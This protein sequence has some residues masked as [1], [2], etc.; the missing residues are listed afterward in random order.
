MSPAKTDIQATVEILNLIT[1][2]RQARDRQWWNT[3]RQCYTE[4]AIIEVGWFHGLASEYINQSIEISKGPFGLPATHRVGSPVIHVNG[5]RAVA[6][7]PMIVDFRGKVRKVE[8]D[9]TNYY[10]MLDRLEKS[11]GRWRI[12]ESRA[13]FQS[14]TM[15]PT[16][17]GT[18]FTLTP[19]DFEGLRPS[20]RCML[21]L[22]NPA[23]HPM[24]QECH[25]ID[26]PDAVAELYRRVYGWAGV[27]IG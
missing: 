16:I 23:K 25:G 26:R 9:V 17:P 7:I 15:E 5:D 21:L 1:H 12:A 8:V 24:S 27:D 6:E 3:L 18:P 10:R 20:Y 4:D 2:E 19:A 13:I 11:D 22:V 14:D